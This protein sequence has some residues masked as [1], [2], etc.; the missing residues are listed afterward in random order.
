MKIDVRFHQL[1][2]SPALREH[3]QRAI[4]ARLSRF[5]RAIRSVSVRLTDLNGPGK[6]GTDKRCYVGLRGPDLGALYVEERS[7]DAAS[8]VDLALEQAARTAGSRL[9]KSR[10]RRRAAPAPALVPAG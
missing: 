6:G 10:D 4:H 8:A 2:A 7:G 9:D 1:E 5:G 3:V